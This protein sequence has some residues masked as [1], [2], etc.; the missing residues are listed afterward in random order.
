MKKN[1][2]MRLAGA[3]LVLT[4]ITSCFVGGTFAKYV[5]S[6][7]GTDTA[8]VA[9]FGV[10][11]SSEST[12]FNTV[13]AKDGQVAS[14]VTNSVVSSND[15][16]LVAPGTKGN[17]ASISISG[18]PEVDVKVANNF[19]VTLND[20]W[21]DA[22][23]NFYC[24]IVITVGDKQLKGTGYQSREDFENAI[25]AAVEEKM[26]SKDFKANTDLANNVDL[27]WAWAFEG[28]DDVKDTFLGNQSKAG[29]AATITFNFTTTVTQID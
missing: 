22:E 13:Y 1:K 28:N 3:L 11:V 27:K 2:T 8:R 7:T 16:K 4:L 14:I 29:K 21:K 24:P 12:A 26:P 23:E 20:N 10:E 17:L 25:K 5:T 19:T 6:T 18:Q 9:K 15:E